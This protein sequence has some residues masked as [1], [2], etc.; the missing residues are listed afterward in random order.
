MIFI[1]KTDDLGKLFTLNCFLNSLYRIAIAFYN[2]TKTDTQISESLKLL[3]ILRR[4]D[5]SPGF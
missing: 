2:V 4:L 3:Y 5:V 1:K